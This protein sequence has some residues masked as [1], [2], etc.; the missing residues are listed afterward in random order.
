MTAIVSPPR[1]RP[2]APAPVRPF[3][4]SAVHRHRLPNG[5]DVLYASGASVPIFAATVLLR[6]GSSSD[7]AGGE[8]LASLTAQLLTEGTRSYDATELARRVELLG[9]TLD[10]AT[11]ADGTAVRLALLE[12]HAAEGLALLAEAVTS[13]TF[14]PAEI[15][16]V[17]GLRLDSIRQSRD[18]PGTLAAEWLTGTLYGE[19]PYAHPAYGRPGSIRRLTREAIVDHHQRTFRPSNAVAVVAGSLPP[20]LVFELVEATLGEWPV[21]PPP[22][23]APLIGPPPPKRRVIVVDRPV[24]VQSVIRI[25]HLGV[26]R[27]HADDHA[28]QVANTILGGSFTS[29]VNLNLR[30]HHGY[31]YGARTSF[32]GRRFAG[33]F[34]AA[35]DVES[36]VT[37]PATTELLGELDRIRD[38][39][40]DT[41]ELADAKSYLQG[42]FPYLLETPRDLASRLVDGELYG[43]PSDYLETYREIVGRVTA[44]DVLRVAR[45]H[46]SPSRTLILVVGGAEGIVD[47]LSR[48]GPVEVVAIDDHSA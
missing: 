45:A 9:G 21:S 13:P 43:L 27:F 24:A 10:A 35:A 14:P 22:P 33:L 31:T 23:P 8:G 20:E 11:V 15:E 12:R 2:P 34:V 4:L 44:E 40:V 25:A 26:P 37:I 36:S 18:Q 32:E 39:E 16:R 41:A 17:R 28:L 46:V 6:S 29:R 47:G 5:L 19:T 3:H 1:D 7:P 48:F 42:V 30:E 38:A